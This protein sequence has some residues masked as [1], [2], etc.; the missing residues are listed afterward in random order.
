MTADKGESGFT[1]VEVLV[2]ISIIGALM[3]LLLPAVQSSREAA[4]RTLCTNNLK[5]LGLAMQ[6]HH[7]G[8]GEY[9]SGGWG[10]LWVG[11]ADRGSGPR[12]P[13]GWIY[14]L[15]P[16]LEQTELHRLGSGGDAAAKVAAADQL[17][18]YSLP[19]FNC[20]SRRNAGLYPYLVKRPPHNGSMVM[21]VAKSDYAVNAGDNDPGT[22][23][24]PI[25]LEEGDWPDFPW[26]GF[27]KATGICYYHSTVSMPQI[28]DG[29]T[30]TY[31]VGEKHCLSGDYD[32][33]DDESMYV[34][35]D[36][37]VSRW[38]KPN[39]PPQPD[40]NVSYRDRFGSAHSAGCNFVFCD[41]AVR[42][43][44]YDIDGEIHRRLGNR[45]DL[46]PVVVD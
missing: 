6:S 27:S 19:L 7:S 15:L 31:C 4:R 2:I 8:L 14:S 3:A 13:G 38:T 37:D 22:G 40:G 18:Q 24:T 42:L 10:H 20:P 36:Y 16:Y 26:A 46:L 45:R 43:I 9:P 32:G 44:D 41:G 34:G 1:L 23:R 21:M 39:S 5:Q 29:N 28:R 30:N 12:Q 33:G 35:Y 17:V 25:S 11:D